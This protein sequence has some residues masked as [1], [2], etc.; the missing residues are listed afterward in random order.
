LQG[1][2]IQQWTGLLDCNGKEIYEGDI[3][4]FDDSQTAVKP[5]IGLAEV[6][7]CSD[8]SLSN[9]PQWGLWYIGKKSGFSPYMLGRIEVIGNIFDNPELC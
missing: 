9:G 6:I 1:R 7:W 5:T 3:V 8:L 2:V 4:H